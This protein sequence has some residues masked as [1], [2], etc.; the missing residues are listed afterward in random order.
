MKNNLRLAIIS[1]DPTDNSQGVERFCHTLSSSVRPHGIDTVVMGK[2][3]FNAGDFDVVVTNALV[4]VRTKLPRIHVFHGCHV[5]Q[6]L[7]SHVDASFQWR[8]RYMVISVFRE[9]TAG[10]GATRISVSRSCAREIRRWYR[11]RSK[12]I[13]NGI[14]T[15]IFRQR[16]KNESRAIMGI[17][18]TARMALFIGRPEWRKRPDIALEAASQHGY[19]LYLAAGRPFEGMNW[20]GKLNPD[21][22]ATA[23]AASDVVLM[24][25]QYEACSLAMLEAVAVGTPVITSDAGWVPDLVAAVPGYASLVTRVGATDEFSR[26]LMNLDEASGAVESAA[27]YVRESNS[28]ESFGKAWA[29]QIWR[30]HREAADGY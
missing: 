30:A 10:L 7:V 6:N 18:P 23:I 15:E 12:V 17:E 13:S 5:P 19:T 9:F 16:D 11:M 20:L 8:A 27:V 26:S 22:L 2:S 28:I 4:N 21:E 25:T 29:T 1:P 3:D 24:P 14:D